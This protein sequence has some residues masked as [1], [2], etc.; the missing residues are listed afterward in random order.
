M[1]SLFFPLLL[2]A[3]A[4]LGHIPRPAAHCPGYRATNIHQNPSYATAD[5]VLIDNCSLYSKDIQSLRL[6]VEYETETRLHVLIEDAGKEVYQ[7][8]EHVLARP[9]TQNATANEAA[10]KFSF[11]EDPFTFTITRASNGE[12]LFD[13]SD[14]PLNFESQYVRVR[15][16]LP[17]NPN[18]YG[19]GEHSDDFRLPTSNYTRTLWNAEFPFI[20][21]RTNLYGSHPV[22][23]DHRGDSGTH[24]VFLLNSNGMDIIIDKT[25]LGQQYLEYNIIGGVLDFYFVAGPEPAEVSKQYAEIVGLPAMIPYWTLGFHQCKYGWPTIDH[26]AEVVANY[27][28]AGIPLET[29]W[30][31]I[32]YMRDKLDFTTDPSRYPLA[33]VRTLVDQLHQS[34]QHYIQILD[35]GIRRHDDY[36]PYTRGA[37]K[38]AFLRATDGSYYRGIQWPG[39]V[40]WPDWFAPGTQDWWT[41][42]ILSFYSPSTGID[43]DGLW[44]DMNEASNMCPDMT[45][46]TST[47]STTTNPRQQQP[48]PQPH[49]RQPPSQGGGQGPKLGLPN[50]DLLSPGYH[51]ASRH[52]GTLSAFT[53]STNLTNADGSHQYDTHNLYGSMMARATH[54]ALITRSPTKRPFVLTR[55]TFAGTGSHAAHWFG[56]NASTWAHYRAAIRQLLA[57][58]AVHAL[59]MV[60][61]DVCG[62]NGDAEERMCARWAVMAAWQP[63]YRNHADASAPDQEFY[64]WPLVAEAARKAVGVRYRL[65]DYLY[66]AMWRASREGRAVV[67]PLWFF[68]PGDAATWGVQTQWFLGEALLVSPVV[69][70]D[71]QTVRFY[72]PRDVWYDFWTGE[73]VVSVGG[74]VTREGVEWADIPVHIRGGSIVPMRVRSA[75][76]TAEL[77]KEN[78]VITVAP[79]AD[80]TARGELYLDDGES[81]DVG[82]NKSVLTLTWNGRAVE[83]SG[84]FGYATDLVIERVV[85]LGDGGPRTQEG[86]WR[87]HKAFILRF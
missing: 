40:V 36:G 5:L 64:R 46:L 69:D 34:N 72:L 26:V 43:V 87:L 68:Y 56:D 81:L 65:L 31:D 52:G 32:D 21:S 9:K 22:Y 15:T 49:R 18:L 86:P 17:L 16:R 62:F 24:G 47:T 80:G 48:P 83:A 27:S 25:E 58:A 84:M 59:P 35:P 38:G 8:Q 2:F 33:K 29:V 63:F 41:S 75:N 23:F 79:G 39:E 85:V 53:L 67:S 13:T 74:M 60:G 3:A 11:T 45:C 37:E 6:L 19:L 73:K 12:V 57:A 1:A 78:F 4:V 70:D 28:A 51:I 54:R 61:S 42:E 77:R 55:S 14:S 66:T 76:T 10:L 44:V 71:S 20:P 82:D 7:V 30:G 50:R